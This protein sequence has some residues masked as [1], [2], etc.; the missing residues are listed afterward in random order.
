MAA[1]APSPSRLS[2][3]LTP[4]LLPRRPTALGP[5]RPP[6]CCLPTET[7]DGLPQ[8]L[9]ATPGNQ[10]RA[11]IAPASLLATSSV[12]SGRLLNLSTHMFDTPGPRQQL[13]PL[14][15]FTSPFPSMYMIMV[16]S[17]NESTLSLGLAHLESLLNSPEPL[18]VK[19][20]HLESKWRHTP[21]S[22][23]VP[24]GL[25]SPGWSPESEELLTD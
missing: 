4:P 17:A 16:S 15:A 8:R 24:P 14:S 9:S 21:S 2:A 6:S 20:P 11:T 7:L 22:N 19:Y 18:P 5:S 25:K 1:S 3:C 13:S 23:T 12:T 10:G